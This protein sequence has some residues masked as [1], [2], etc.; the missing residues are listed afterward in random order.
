MTS[1]FA[2]RSLRARLMILVALVVAA[3]VL[4]TGFVVGRLARNATVDEVQRILDDQDRIASEISTTAIE[5]GSWRAA[6]EAAER[7][8]AETGLRIV[9]RDSEGGLLIDTQSGLPGSERTQVLERAP[10]FL[11]PAAELFDVY[12]EE[13]FAD[14]LA[15]FDIE[16]GELMVACLDEAGVP[17][18]IERDPVTGAVVPLSSDFA[19][20]EQCYVES[21]EILSEDE[22][23]GPVAEAFG[24][25]DVVLALEPVLLYFGYDGSDQLGGVGGGISSGVIAVMVAAVVVAIAAMA[26]V[27]RRVLGPVTSLT[28]AVRRMEQGDLSERVEVGGAD[29]LA[30]LGS[31]F[32]DMADAIE[33]NEERRKQLTSDVA[34]ELRTPLANV[35][36]YVEAAQ[37]G[38]VPAGDELLAT[39]HEETI[40]LQAIVEDVQ[41]LS[42]A[43]A[44]RLAVD[45]VPTSLPGVVSS[46][47][48][49]HAARSNERGVSLISTV[50][51]VTVM[52]DPARLRQ[53]LTNLVENALRYSAGGGS[54]E[55]STATVDD[56]VEVSV[57]DTG[58]GMTAAELDRVFDRFYR[59]DGARS[60]ETGGAG[61]G[62]AIVERL[63]TT[64][65]GE[66][67]ATSEVGSGSRFVVSLKRA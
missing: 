12:L 37:D 16:L 13:A 5:F 27:A 36:G 54:V 63:V 20:E 60:R 50:D 34:H 33:M 11:D 61:L 30:R 21:L 7:M 3:A 58:S 1:R 25:P 52:A 56:R 31:A 64:M 14:D 19:V 41:V 44:G 43:D 10:R 57:T 47:V 28:A 42:L 15:E 66:V 53:V 4:A 26:L 6:G 38:V 62:L 29:E 35:R 17:F 9:V 48:A 51:E 65:G 49:A 18:E 24:D 45:V 46:V 67:T 23:F 39:L 55:V 22:Q 2:A 59:S 8:A 40:H 32:N